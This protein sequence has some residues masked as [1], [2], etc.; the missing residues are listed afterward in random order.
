MRVPSLVGREL[1]TP[2]RTRLELTKA[3]EAVRLAA[4]ARTS[5]KVLLVPD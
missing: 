1:E 5:G 4:L 2:V 3:R